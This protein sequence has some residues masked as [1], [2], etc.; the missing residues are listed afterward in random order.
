MEFPLQLRERVSQLNVRQETPLFFSGR[1]PSRQF[2]TPRQ[3]YSEIIRFPARNQPAFCA[4]PVRELHIGHLPT[5]GKSRIQAP[6]RPMS[7][8]EIRADLNPRRAPRRD[9]ISI[10]SRSRSGLED[11]LRH[12]GPIIR[13]E[14]CVSEVT[15]N[16]SDCRSTSHM[17]ETVEMLDRVLLRGRKHRIASDLVNRYPTAIDC[18]T[19]IFDTLFGRN[20]LRNSPLR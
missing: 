18:N 15:D 17:T 2:F 5:V 10:R 20:Y 13:T 1:R 4:L 11:Y 19:L 16:A 3:A 8:A 6:D 9:A 12:V 7:L 14:R